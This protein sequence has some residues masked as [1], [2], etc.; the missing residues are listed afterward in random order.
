MNARAAARRC[1]AAARWTELRPSTPIGATSNRVDDFPLPDSTLYSNA[2]GLLHPPAVRMTPLR[3]APHETLDSY[4]SHPRRLHP[5]SATTR[6]R[7]GPTE[8]TTA[9]PAVSR[10]RRAGQLPQGRLRRVHGRPLPRRGVHGFEQPG[11]EGL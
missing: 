2:R 7:A 1:D 4:R 6:L 8:R 5:R 10:R 9:E 11:D 3:A